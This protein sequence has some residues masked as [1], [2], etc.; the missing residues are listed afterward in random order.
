ME[1]WHAFLEFEYANEVM[2]ILGTFL[3]IIGCLLY[4]SPSP[5]D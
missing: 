5:R 1:Y 3:V 4:T 2:M